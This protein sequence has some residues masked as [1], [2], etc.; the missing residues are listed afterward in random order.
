MADWLNTKILFLSLDM[1]SGPTVLVSRP[2]VHRAGDGGRDHDADAAEGHHALQL[3]GGHGGPPGGDRM[4]AGP[5]RR[6][7][8][9]GQG[10]MTIKEPLFPEAHGQV[11]WIHSSPPLS[12]ACS[13]KFICDKEFRGLSCN[14]PSH[15]WGYE[16]VWKGS[17][18]PFPARAPVLPAGHLHR[19]RGPA[20]RHV[21]HCPRCAAPAGGP[22]VVPPL[23]LG[24]AF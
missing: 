8:A 11:G 20:H 13:R 19:D 2:P 14:F 12:S 23:R 16:R 9:P 1:S 21:P 17:P 24:I 6:L 5:H 3:P 18:T 7:P 10:W 15:F 22:S 4:E